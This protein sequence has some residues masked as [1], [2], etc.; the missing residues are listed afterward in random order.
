[1]K[2]IQKGENILKKSLKIR[3][4]GHFPRQWAII[5]GNII[6]YNKKHNK[7]FEETILY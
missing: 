4:S 5:N 7:I 3:D 1:M 6:I 2:N